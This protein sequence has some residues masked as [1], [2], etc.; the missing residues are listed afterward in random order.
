MNSEIISLLALLNRN[1]KV[2][3]AALTCEKMYPLYEKFSSLS[4]WGD[5]RIY[6]E[7]IVA[8]YDFVL[9]NPDTS[10]Q[11]LIDEAESIM[12]DL[13]N[14][15]GTA[16]SYALDACTALAEAISFLSDYDD[17]HI[18]N[19]STAA[20]DTVDMYVQVVHDLDPNRP[21]LDIVINSDVVMVNELQR[22]LRLAVKL[23]T[24]SQFNEESISQLRSLNGK[25]DIIDLMSIY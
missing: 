24:I 21:D 2:I 1:Q 22:Q 11:S 25:E 20:T 15:T 9:G 13:D 18:A 19:C 17:S 23:K 6:S 3:F 12:P 5:P 10:Y 4:R 14:F 7:G 8:L 16:P